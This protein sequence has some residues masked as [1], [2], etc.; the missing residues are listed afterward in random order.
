MITLTPE[1]DER[2]NIVITSDACPKEDVHL[3]ILR[4]LTLQ[5]MNERKNRKAWRG[6]D[7]WRH[8]GRGQSVFV[9]FE[10]IA[11]GIE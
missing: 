6:N 5:L 9:E 10:S 4:T 11:E 7:W 8:L 3:I 1:E 2:M